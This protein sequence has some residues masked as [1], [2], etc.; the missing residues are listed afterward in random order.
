MMQQSNQTMQ[1]DM[2]GRKFVVLPNLMHNEK[3]TLPRRRDVFS[4]RKLNSFSH[5]HLLNHVES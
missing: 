1:N 3:V 2:K 4:L 5:R